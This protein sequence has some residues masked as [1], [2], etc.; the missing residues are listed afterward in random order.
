MTHFSYSLRLFAFWF[1]S[2]VMG[3]SP[4]TSSL[5]KKEKGW[6][7]KSYFNKINWLLFPFTSLKA[8]RLTSVKDL[9]FMTICIHRKE[10][11]SSSVSWYIL[12]TMIGLRDAALESLDLL[13][14]V[15][16]LSISF[17]LHGFLAYSTNSPCPGLRWVK[18]EVLDLNLSKLDRN[19]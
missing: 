18:R 19:F 10:A 14:S 11:K 8:L 12:Q 7:R 4:S 6:K 15:L 13:F 2:S 1:R 9:R 3:L 17:L 16:L 5:K